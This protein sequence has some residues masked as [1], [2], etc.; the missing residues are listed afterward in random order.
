MHLIALNQCYTIIVFQVSVFYKFH[1]SSRFQYFLY[2]I[3]HKIRYK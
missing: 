2:N 3:I 1:I